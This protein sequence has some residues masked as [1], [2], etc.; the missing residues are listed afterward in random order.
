M[1]GD[2]G[3]DGDDAVSVE[4]CVFKAIDVD[5]LAVLLGVNDPML[6]NPFTE[7]E[8]VEWIT[9]FRSFDPEREGLNVS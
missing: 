3:N 8:T 7:F 4:P 2:R 9:N 1:T 5:R 6:H